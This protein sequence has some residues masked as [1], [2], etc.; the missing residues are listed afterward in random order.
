MAAWCICKPS[1]FAKNELKIIKLFEEKTSMKQKKKHIPNKNTCLVN[2]DMI[3]H[4]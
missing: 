2:N 3:D 4:E 1:P